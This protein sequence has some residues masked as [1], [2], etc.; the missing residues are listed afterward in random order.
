MITMS[1]EKK[2]VNRIWKI[3][4]SIVVFL[5]LVCENRTNDDAG[6]L[7][8]HFTSLNVSLTEQTSS[9]NGRSA[10]VTQSLTL[11]KKVH[12]FRFM[13]FWNDVNGPKALIHFLSDLSRK[14]RTNL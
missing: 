6:V 5:P 3:H 2:S 10:K 13:V 4:L 7:D 14:T 1:N 12:Y 11:S 8:N 9:V